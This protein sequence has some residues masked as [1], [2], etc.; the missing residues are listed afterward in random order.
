VLRKLGALALRPLTHGFLL[1][2]EPRVIR[3][4]QFGIYIGLIY[5][6]IYVLF[7]PP[8]SFENV[9]GQQLVTI[10]GGFVAGGAVLGAVAVLPG[11]WWLER[12]GILSLV[13]GLSL[14]AVI[15]V[16]LGVSVVG[17]VVCI[18]FAA[19]FVQRW[20][21]IRGSQLAPKRG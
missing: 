12:A 10:F 21:E 18:C 6:G 7:A 4:I 11:I 16:S 17:T 9:L 5:V 2:A 3:I 13:T 15:A 20:M 19:T 1:I 14:Y 8:S